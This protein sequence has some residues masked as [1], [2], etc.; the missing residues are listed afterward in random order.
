MPIKLSEIRAQFPMYAD[1]PDDQL[2]IG[3]HRKFYSDI[4]FKQFNSQIVYDNKPDATEGMSGV[5]KFRAG[6][7]KAM[8]DTARGLG[9]MV[10]LANRSDVG[11]ARKLDA[12]L[13]KTSEGKWGE[14]ASNVA[15][16]VP[17][18]FVPGANTL[19]GAALLGAGTGLAQQ[20]ESTG[21]TLQ[22][23]GL[24]GVAG[25]GGVLAGRG[26]GAAYQVGTG[27]LRPFTRK[28]QEQIA[29]EVLQASATN[30]AKAA[31]NLANA[32]PLVPGSAPT[33]GQ[34]ADDAG[35]AQLERTLLN[36]PE[37]AG[38]LNM[39]YEAQQAARRKAVEGVAGTPGY[40]DLI[41]QGRDI[42]AKQ[43]YAQA[44]AQGIDQNMAQAL[45][46]QIKNLMQRPSVQQAQAVAKRLAA[47]EGVALNDFGSVQGL[48]WLKK[49][50]D[51]EISRAAAPGSSIGKAEFRALMQ[52]KGDLMQVL[53]QIAPAYKAANDN[54]AGMSRSINSM[55]V[56]KQLQDTLY[57]NAQF[58]S[59]K[60]LGASYQNQLAKA[61]ESVKK[62][63]GIDVPLEQVMTKGDYDALVS[64]AKD[65]ARKENAQ[66]LGR[67]VGSPTM[68]NMMGQNLLKRLLGPLGAPETLSQNA[69]AQTLL[70]PY[71]FATSAALPKIEATL[72]ETMADPATARL[73][74]LMAQQPSVMQRLGAKT[75][76]FLPVPGLL[77]LEQ[78]P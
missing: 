26:L 48:D 21:E 61:M 59:G 36:K 16:T 57:K 54:F 7:G 73:R 58:G 40:R 28:G 75:E 34:V 77:A 63:L 29:A 33:V 18:A 15:T 2:L 70:R 4:P 76:R 47:E 49:A 67:A 32:R 37:T 27:L 65:L 20:S 66:N 44:M 5:D 43:D 6:M 72:A 31:A 64:V 13:G 51:N 42:F 56:A 52:S 68:Q 14:F 45:Q 30:P 71:G 1:V 23:I 38:P 62:Q 8:T 17:L 9:Q 74:L 11:E 10:G 12:D 53:E 24:G 55:D 35:L 50:L 25:A 69:L 3:L 41:A 60:E 46:P 78:G 19:L 39:A 22:N